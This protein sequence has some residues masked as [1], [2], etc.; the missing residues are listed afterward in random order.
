M[1]SKSGTFDGSAFNTSSFNY[2]D[3][4]T[5]GNGYFNDLNISPEAVPEPSTMVLG[6]AGMASLLWL[7]RR[8]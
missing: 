6:A 3:S 5:T 1:N 8:R 7:R 4:N 2:L